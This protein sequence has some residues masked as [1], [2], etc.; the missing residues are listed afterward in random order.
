MKILESQMALPDRMVAVAGVEEL[1]SEKQKEYSLL[2]TTV[3][4]IEELSSLKTWHPKA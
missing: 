1:T 2:P 4:Y 3:A